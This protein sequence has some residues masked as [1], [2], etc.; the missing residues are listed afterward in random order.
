MNSCRTQ[1]VDESKGPIISIRLKHTYMDV[2]MYVLR[3]VD[4]G[5]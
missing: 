4:L 3:L 1:Q 2:Y 5:I